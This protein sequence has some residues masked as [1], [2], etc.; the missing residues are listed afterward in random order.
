MIAY[1]L[2]T[3]DSLAVLAGA[4]AVYWFVDL[5][6]RRFWRHVLPSEFSIDPRSALILGRHTMDVVACMVFM[7]LG[8]KAQYMDEDFQ[9]YWS[10]EPYQRFYSSHRTCHLLI[11]VQLAY[12]AKNL[13][14]SYVCGDGALFYAHHIGTGILCAF[15]LA[16]FIQAYAPFF[17]GVTEISTAILCILGLFDDDHGVVGLGDMY[18]KTKVVVGVVFASVFIPVRNVFWVQESYTFW[19]DLLVVWQVGPRSYPAIIYAGTINVLLTLLQ[20]YW[21]CE[22]LWTARKNWALFASVLGKDKKS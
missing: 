14:D 22:I 12:Q 16:P 21:T 15:A 7:Y 8:F 5:T 2:S 11:L 18:P 9:R 20:F 1:E 10:M 13:I 3:G 17:L 6:A 19:Q 4:T